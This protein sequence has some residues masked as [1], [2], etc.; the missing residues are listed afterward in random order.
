MSGTS[1]PAAQPQPEPASAADTPPTE[2]QPAEPSLADRVATLEA[3]M[4][5]LIGELRRHL[6]GLAIGPD[7]EL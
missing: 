4:A 6:G 7:P 1:D 2:G 3:R 5:E